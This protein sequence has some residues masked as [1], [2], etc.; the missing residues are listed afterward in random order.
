[1]NTVNILGIFAFNSYSHNLFQ[2]KLMQE[3]L[4][5][6]HNIT[7]LSPTKFDIQHE[8]FTFFKF[9]TIDDG[10]NMIEN[11]LRKTRNHMMKSI[12]KFYS[13][14]EMYIR[15]NDLEKLVKNPQSNSFD[16]LIIECILCPFVIL[17]EVYD[18]PIVLSAAFNINTLAHSILGNSLHPAAHLDLI[19]S[20]EIHG[21]LGLFERIASFMI[22]SFLG[23][24]SCYM[25]FRDMNSMIKEIYP[26]STFRTF[27]EIFFTRC[28]LQFNAENF[29]TSNLFPTVTSFHKIGFAHLTESTESRRY[30]YVVLIST[31]K[32]QKR[33]SKFK[34]FLRG[35]IYII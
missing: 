22:T 35:R 30:V 1:M 23:R 2:L 16:L 8:N 26:D 13:V 10:L 12:S 20:S 19:I 32:I 29:A 34:L 24:I 9:E 21:N 4:I 28:K 3:L 7:V 18:C 33:L 31:A 5:N 15:S 6:G 25:H 11:K 17:A 27:E 14:T